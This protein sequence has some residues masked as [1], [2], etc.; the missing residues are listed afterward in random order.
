MDSKEDLIK[1]EQSRDLLIKELND[2]GYLVVTYDYNY[3]LPGDER[4][5]PGIEVMQDIITET[6]GD[7]LTG[8]ID[9]IVDEEADEMD[10]LTK[11]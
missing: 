4:V 1:R 3:R 6:H 9:T 8:E 2:I 7:Y 11:K 5:H 10:F